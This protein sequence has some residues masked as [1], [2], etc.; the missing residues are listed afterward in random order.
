MFRFLKKTFEKRQATAGDQLAA[1]AGISDFTTPLSVRESESYIPW[2]LACVDFIAKSVS[3][4]PV[5]LCRR[6]GTEKEVIEDHAVAELLKNPHPRLDGG[7]TEI[8]LF[9]TTELIELWQRDYSHR[10]N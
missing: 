2:V 4:L 10:R 1:I 7:M 3:S 9:A 6:Q 5:R 8:L